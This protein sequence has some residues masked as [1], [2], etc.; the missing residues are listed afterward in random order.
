MAVLVV[1]AKM[2]KGNIW[3]AKNSSNQTRASDA[4]PVEGFLHL[5]ILSN[6]AYHRLF[7]HSTQEYRENIREEMDICACTNKH[8]GALKARINACLNLSRASAKQQDY[9]RKDQTVLLNL[10]T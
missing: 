4:K 3:L 5:C 1:P 10:L 8:L 2:L 6:E 9:V 7:R